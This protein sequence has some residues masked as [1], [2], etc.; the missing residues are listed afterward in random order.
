MSKIDVINPFNGEKFGEYQLSSREES[1]E[2]LSKV[3][4]GLKTQRKLMPFQRSEILSKLADLLESHRDELSKLIAMEIGKGQSECAV[5]ISRA[6][7]VTRCAAEAAREHGGEVLHSDAYMN[8]GGKRC[9]VEWRPIGVVLAITPFN[10]PINL[11]IHKIAPGFAAGCTL[12]FKSGPANYLSGKRL[13]E[14]CWE[15]GFPKDTIQFVM[16]DIPVMEELIQHKFVDC[17]SFTGG[18]PT[19]K[20]IAK[21]SGFKKLLFELG[22][23]DPLIVMPDADV[24]TAAATAINQRFG[25]SGQR[26]TASKRVFVH[27]E[28]YDKFKS[29]L[30]DKTKE[31]IVGDPLDPNTFMGPLVNEK[32]AIE[33]EKRIKDA[34]EEGAIILTGGNREGAIVYPTV[35]ENLNKKSELICDETFG[36]VIPLIK[37]S[38]LAEVIETVNESEFGLQSGVF[39]N[40]IR[41]AERLYQELEVGAVIVNSGPG[42]RADHFPFGGVKDSGIGREGVRY[43]MEEMMVRKSL[44]I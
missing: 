19:A 16:P 12:L 31:V 40:D 44:V 32:A 18:V 8:M 36:P 23:N 22:G 30:L 33:V 29:I 11:A 1:L 5:E 17:I 4:A 41:V 14:L 35:M 7:G 2:A 37:F 21:K 13:T 3:R 10:F 9:I 20:A 27:A 34:A 38:E 26:C 39:T 6:V 24:E 43:A 25:S 42:Y 15:A 28:V